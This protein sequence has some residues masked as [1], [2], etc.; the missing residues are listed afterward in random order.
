MPTEHEVVMQ[1]T[2]APNPSH[3]EFVNPVVEGMSRAAGERRDR[4]G[5]ASLDVGITLPVL[6]HG[7]AS[8][9]G[10][11]VVAETLNLS[12]LPGYTTGGTI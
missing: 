11:G 9:P 1:V 4:A 10:Q 5:A 2:L 8:F 12:R 6:I 7:D 3:L